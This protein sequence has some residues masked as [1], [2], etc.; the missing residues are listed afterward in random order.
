MTW[1]CPTC[2]RAHLNA[3]AGIHG[4]DELPAFCVDCAVHP[5]EI[6]AGPPE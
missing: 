5:A 2:S 4:P 6:D 1:I 3:S